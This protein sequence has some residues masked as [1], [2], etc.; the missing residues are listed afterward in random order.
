MYLLRIS[1][2]VKTIIQLLG[3]KIN[4]K[5]TTRNKI[6]KIEGTSRDDDTK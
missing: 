2:F 5:V 4:S 3:L 6:G 1:C